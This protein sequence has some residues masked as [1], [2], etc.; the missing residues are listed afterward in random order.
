MMSLKPKTILV[1]RDVSDAAEILQ[2]NLESQYCVLIVDEMQQA[3][4]YLEA[5][6]ID[7]LIQTYRR[8]DSTD[9]DYLCEQGIKILLL[10]GYASTDIIATVTKIKGYYLLKPF[11]TEELLTTIQ[12]I[13]TNTS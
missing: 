6:E 2:R 11:T 13:L 12:E 3:R 9:F 8:E 1:V 10:T 4:D 7:L 5:R